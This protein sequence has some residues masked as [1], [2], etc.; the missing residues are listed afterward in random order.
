MSDDPYETLGVGRDA[1]P[2]EITKA[3][4]KAAREN[5]PDRNPGDSE[6]ENRYLAACEAFSLL[7]DPDRRREYD[8]TGR[9]GQ[10][11]RP[12]AAFMEVL[13]RVM[14]QEIMTRR[15]S[16]V[17]TD[18]VGAMRSVIEDFKSQIRQKVKQAEADKKRF[19]EVK[20]RLTAEDG[21][22]N[23]LV[24]SLQA[25]IA[26]LERHLIDAA[27]EM[28]KMDKALAYL[29]KLSYR[30]DQGKGADESIQDS[31]ASMF[32]MFSM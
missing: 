7:D 10:K 25:E 29:A 19:I 11:R 32:R 6:A 8:Q 20:S 27:A 9:T 3:Y 30:S 23:F 12:E 14:M 2:E 15:D 17:R 18:L 16:V 22:E 13:H 5:H 31:I 24:T 4:R 21:T 28:D 1:S 26:A